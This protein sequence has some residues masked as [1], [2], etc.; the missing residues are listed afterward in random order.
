MSRRGDSKDVQKAM[1]LG[2]NDFLPKPLDD[3][4]LQLKLK[5][6]FPANEKLSGFTMDTTTI[7]KTYS[8]GIVHFEMEL[9]SVEGH[10]FEVRGDHFLVKESGIK[11]TGGFVQEI[12]LEETKHFRVL[13]CS[14]NLETKKYHAILSK[15]L[16]QE[17]VFTLR[18][19]IINMHRKNKDE[20]YET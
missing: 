1:E 7:L 6:Y 8:E 9:V 2:A 18:R 16:S 11:I 13:E 10:Q 20:I 12:F 17:E 3:Q 15:E 19:W 4:F 14:Q 5:E